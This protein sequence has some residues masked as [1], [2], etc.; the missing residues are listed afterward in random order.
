[1]VY[2]QQYD[3]TILKNVFTLKSTYLCRVSYD[4]LENVVLY[5]SQVTN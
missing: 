5:R 3:K 4:R 2:K 1:M